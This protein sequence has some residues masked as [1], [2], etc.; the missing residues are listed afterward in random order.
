MLNYYEAR[1]RLQPVGEDEA[2]ADAFVPVVVLDQGSSP[3]ADDG[4]PRTDPSTAA[5]TPGATF[6]R[7]PLA[8]LIPSSLNSL[9]NRSVANVA[10]FRLFGAS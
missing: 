10:R 2:R 6:A 3:S 1:A 5:V 4:A 9:G 7:L 8:F